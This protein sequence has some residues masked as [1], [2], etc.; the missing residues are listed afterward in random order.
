MVSGWISS[1]LREVSNI[2]TLG[3]FITM[4]LGDIPRVGDTIQL[5]DYLLEIVDMDHVRVDKVLITKVELDVE[6]EVD[7]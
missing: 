3:G 5:G 7:D 2:H 4:S 1:W 6:V